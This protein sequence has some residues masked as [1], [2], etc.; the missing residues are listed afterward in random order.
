MASISAIR[1]GLAANLSTILDVQV[2]AYTL[3]QPTPPGL[4]ILPPGVQYDRTMQGSATSA[5][6]HALD[7]WTFM[8][9]G[10]V[11]LTTDIG[12]QVLL[13]Q[14][15]APSGVNSV[16]AAL[17]SNRTLNGIVSDLHV[18]E[19]SQGALVQFPNGG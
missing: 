1:A 11:A 14:M 16:K 6:R 8:V 19:Q 3:A 9:Q 18:E 4:Q 7:D 2:S 17:E 15:C 5:T 10:F 12:S 13:D